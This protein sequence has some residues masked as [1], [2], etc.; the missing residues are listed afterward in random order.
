M[1]RTNIVALETILELLTPYE[2]RE[3]KTEIDILYKIVLENK[4]L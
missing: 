2:R 1:K 3:F 4:E